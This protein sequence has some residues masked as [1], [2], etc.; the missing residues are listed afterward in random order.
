MGKLLKQYF[1]IIS[2]FFLPFL[3][4][5]GPKDQNCLIKMKVNI[6]QIRS[7]CSL[8]LLWTEKLFWGKFRPKIQNYF[9]KTKLGAWKNSNILNSVVRFTCLAL[10][11]KYPF[12]G[13]FSPK[14]QNC[15][16]WNL[17]SRLIQIYWIQWCCTEFICPALDWKYF[18]CLRSKQS[19]LSI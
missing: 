6:C 5:L 8:Y 18:L 12:W 4:K 1:Y 14:N 2:A 16:T 3:D 13:K 17:E 9:F 7:C 19:N 10:D 11:E 15:L